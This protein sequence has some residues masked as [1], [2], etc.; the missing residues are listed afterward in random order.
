[1]WAASVAGLSGLTDAALGCVVLTAPFVFLFVFAGGGAGDAKLMG[2]LGAWL[3]VR[4][5]LVALVCVVIAGGVLGLAFALAQKRLGPVFRNFG[6]LLH[7]LLIHLA[8]RSFRNLTLELPKPPKLNRMPYGPAI[9]VGV[10]VAAMGVNLWG[11]G[12]CLP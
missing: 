10:C 11:W 12:A 5:G 9:F 6:G 4:H 3:G 2:A 8:I 1:V 7:R